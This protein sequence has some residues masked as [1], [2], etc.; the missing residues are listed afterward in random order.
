MEYCIEF[1]GQQKSSLEMLLLEIVLDGCQDGLG[2][3]IMF[4][5]LPNH[6]N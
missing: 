2:M 6:L 1:N 4:D 5:L 3:V